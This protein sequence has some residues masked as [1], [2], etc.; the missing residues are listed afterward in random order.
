MASSRSAAC[1]THPAHLHVWPSSAAIGPKEHAARSLQLTCLGASC[2]SV[3]V[4][5]ELQEEISKQM[6]DHPSDDFK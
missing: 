2:Q 1:C 4:A 5:T 3:L 6:F